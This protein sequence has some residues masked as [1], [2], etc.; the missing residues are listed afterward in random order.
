MSDTIQATAI[1]ALLGEVIDP[2]GSH[3]IA[4][5]DPIGRY[6]SG[7]AGALAALAAKLNRSQ[8]FQ[9]YGLALGPQDLAE[10]ETLRDVLSA[11][12]RWFQ[13]SGWVVR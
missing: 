13:E 5:D 3:Q 4:W 11:I 2:D 10:V 9:G 12:I 8:E 7:G 6:L 1:A